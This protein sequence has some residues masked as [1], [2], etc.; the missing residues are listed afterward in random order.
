VYPDSAPEN[1]RD[2]LRET[3][4]Q[5]AISPLH[6]PVDGHDESERK[7]HWHV[8]LCWESGSTT[9]KVAQS[10]ADKVNAPI[11][12][13]LN[14]VKGSYDYLTHKN[15]P[16]KEQLDVRDIEHINGFNIRDYADMTK[17]EI[18]AVKRLI[19]Q[20]ISVHD[21]VEYWDLM[22]CLD[23]EDVPNAVDMYEVA[24]NNTIFCTKLLDSRRNKRKDRQEFEAAVKK[25]AD[26]REKC[27][28]W[29]EKN[30]A[31]ENKNATESGL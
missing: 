1:W 4:L 11:P 26:W 27:E 5:G 21:L 16:E 10:I 8:M 23:S 19:Q 2:I 9:Q 6:S 7:A 24:A 30:A 28:K 31:N 15:N 18:T 25:E 17:S 29:K 22:E 14:N 12:R 3:G 13:A 20:F